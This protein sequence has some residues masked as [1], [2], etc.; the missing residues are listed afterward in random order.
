[1]KGEPRATMIGIND[2]DIITRNN[3]I[4]DHWLAGETTTEI[5]EKSHLDRSQIDNIIKHGTASRLQGNPITETPPIY[6]VWNY[7]TCD[8]RFGQNYP[9]R[10]PGQAIVNL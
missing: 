3:A 8:P 2:K 10:I 7:G 4:F 9:G 6:N 5:A 1:V